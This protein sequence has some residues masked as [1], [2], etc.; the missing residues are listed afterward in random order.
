MV[1][2]TSLINNA[3]IFDEA[4]GPTNLSAFENIF[5]INFLAQIRMIKHTLEIMKSGK[6]INLSSVHGK[7]GHGRPEAIAY[8]AMKSAL[9]SYTKNLAKELAPKILV[10]AVA[11]G[12]TL[13]PMWGDLKKSEEKDLANGHL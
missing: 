10:N 13:T 4:D 8:S 11:P 6:I 9:D 3:G 1:N 7:I 2:L 12:R 5:R